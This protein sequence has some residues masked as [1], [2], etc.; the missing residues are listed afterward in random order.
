MMMMIIV[1]GCLCALAARTSLLYAL[2]L[3]PSTVALILDGPATIDFHTDL[4]CE[5]VGSSSVTLHLKRDG[6]GQAWLMLSS[7]VAFQAF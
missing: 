6:R 1:T 2:T 3:T 5:I 4:N 7:L